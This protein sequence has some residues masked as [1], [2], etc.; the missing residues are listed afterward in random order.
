M[1]SSIGRR[2]FLSGA[3][4]LALG[5]AWAKAQ[6]RRLVCVGAPV[7]EI[8]FA[9]G[10]GDDVVAVDTTSHHPVAVERLPKV[11]YMRNLS[12]EGLMS[13]SPTH[14]LAHDG[15]GP[16]H[17]LDQVAASGIAVLRVP[18]ELTAA[19][20]SAKVRRIA[21][22]IGRGAAG[23]DLAA[24][25]ERQLGTLSAG[26]LGGDLGGRSILCLAHVGSGGVLAAGQGTVA[27]TLIQLAGGRNAMAAFASY[28]PLSVEAAIAAQ[29]QVLLVAHATV[30]QV[31]GV[32]ALL[33]LPELA[34]TPAAQAR[35]LVVVDGALLLGLGPRTPDAVVQLARLGT[36]A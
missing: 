36:G 19:G 33:A 7:T 2:V 16:A 29:P 26:N 22:A 17:V 6:G 25:L 13:L 27:D 24:R 35:R 3:A 1:G 4:A 20:L 21:D 28:R 11:G 10:G 14:V 34:L 31:G 23:V 8:V 15:S 12:A 5:P 30:A 9:L 18:E 32:D